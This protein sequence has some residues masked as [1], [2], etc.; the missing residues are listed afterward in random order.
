MIDVSAICCLWGR[1]NIFTHRMLFLDKL[2]ENI[3]T[4]TAVCWGKEN[5]FPLNGASGGRE[6]FSPHYCLWG[7][8]NFFPYCCL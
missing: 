8:K 5:I 6:I 2:S 4:L 3:F 7:R 1:E